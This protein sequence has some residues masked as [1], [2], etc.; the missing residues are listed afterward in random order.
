MKNL[1]LFLPIIIAVIGV[2]LFSQC[3]KD[4]SCKM[5]VTCKYSTNGI[6]AGQAVP[7]AIIT[8]DTSKYHN[9]AVDELIS[10]VNLPSFSDINSWSVDSLYRWF[11]NPANYQYR[12]DANGV[13]EY[14]LPYPALLLV[15]AVKIDAIRDTFDNSIIGYVK[16]TGTVQAQVNEGETTEKTILMVE[17]N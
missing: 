2:V 12:T 8:F 4:H 15:N 7:F 13:F 10:Q 14:T 11:E 3:K 16:Y 6:D 1:R 5:K 17:T 9:G